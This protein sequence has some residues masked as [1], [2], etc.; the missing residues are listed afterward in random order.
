MLAESW[1][2][3]KTMVLKMN[4][5][6]EEAIIELEKLALEAADALWAIHKEKPTERDI[7]A[8]NQDIYSWGRRYGY[9][10]GR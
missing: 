10:P 8:I 1:G 2:M 5:I 6:D 9:P 7:V 3:E 4:D